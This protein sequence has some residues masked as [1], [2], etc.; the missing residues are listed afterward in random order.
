MTD[1]AHHYVLNSDPNISRVFEFIRQHNLP[2]E[3]HLARTRFWVPSGPLYTEFLLC[4][5]HCCPCVDP[6]LDL[7][8]GFPK[9]FS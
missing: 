9:T 2:L 8:T 7:A 4:F 6:T 5:G 1:S 3:V